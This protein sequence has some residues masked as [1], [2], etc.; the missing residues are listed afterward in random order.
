MH[1]LTV[2]TL[3]SCGEVIG[4][5]ICGSVLRN[6]FDLRSD[7]DCL[8]VYRPEDH[9]KISLLL[10][11]IVITAREKYIPLKLIPIDS[12]I[13]R[14]PLS[15]IGPLFI[16]HLQ[17]AAE[18]G[19]AIKKNPLKLFASGHKTLSEDIEGY[20][21]DKLRRIGE[22]LVELPAMNDL[23]MYL[24]LQK[25]LEA[26][27]RIARAYLEWR[28]IAIPSG[29]KREIA[30]QYVKN[31]NNQRVEQFKKLVA[32]DQEY[33]ADLARQVKK[34]DQASYERTIEKIKKITWQTFDFIRLNALSLHDE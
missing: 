3:A 21:R 15:H 4:A 14:T 24:F 31:A 10:Q 30:E 12:Q 34:P 32:A 29:L 26:P 13:A 9:E 18:N 19:G 16:D 11:R 27:L 33:S 22:G 6:D 5:V 20:F 23:E 1:A 25:T 28:G 8:V 2:R 7:F 17:W